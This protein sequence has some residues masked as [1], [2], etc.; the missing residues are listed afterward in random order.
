MIFVILNFFMTNQLLRWQIVHLNECVEMF[1]EEQSFNKINIGSNEYLENILIK[2]GIS[3][4][5]K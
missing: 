1:D 5:E 2:L 3:L 4:V